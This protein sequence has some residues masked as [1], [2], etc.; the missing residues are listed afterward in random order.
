MNALTLGGYNFLGGG[1]STLSDDT[2]DALSMVASYLTVA[3]DTLKQGPLGQDDAQQAS[4]YLRQMAQSYGTSDEP[5][6]SAQEAAAAI[7][8]AVAAAR[9]PESKGF[10][11]GVYDWGAGTPAY[12]DATWFNAKREALAV[13]AERV[14]ERA[15]TGDNMAGS[16]VD[17]EVTRRG[18]AAW[19]GAVGR[20][21]LNDGD[22]TQC[23]WLELFTGERTVTQIWPCLPLGAKIFVGVL[24]AGVLLMGVA[25]VRAVRR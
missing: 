6:A 21:N 2:R 5:G 7:D 19:T 13:L 14:R 9:G 3:Y 18:E 20:E 4:M 23:S 22:G 24:G 15:T 16:R 1:S 12:D 8:V 10:W 11:Q 17:N 25:A